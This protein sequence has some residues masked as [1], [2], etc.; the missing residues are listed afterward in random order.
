M[1]KLNLIESELKGLFETLY[2]QED[3][4]DKEDLAQTIRIRFSEALSIKGS[5]DYT[6]HELNRIGKITS[7]DNNLKVFTWHLPK[8]KD[9]YIYYGFLQL[10]EKRG[11]AVH[12]ELIDNRVDRNNS[13]MIQQSPDNWHGKLYYSII[14]KQHRRQTT[15]TLLGMDF[16]NA[17]SNI[18]TVESMIIKRGKP[19]F[20]TSGFEHNGKQEDRL[21]LEYSSQV[22][23][24]VRYNEALDQIVFDHL[25][26]LHAVYT[27]NYEFYGPDGS[28]DGL[29][30]EN[31]TWIYR[32]DLDARNNF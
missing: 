19:Q 17:M 21:V 6:W 28:Y 24:S 22:S 31:G 18:K 23:I 10:R 14:V 16:N 11:E 30:F 3:S 12:V 4:S 32:E 26:P 7:S 13:S 27:G 5:I 8:D 9:T 1:Y 20:T 25:V 29:E 15:Y 2:D